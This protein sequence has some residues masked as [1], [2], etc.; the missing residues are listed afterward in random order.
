LPPNDADF[1]LLGKNE[2]TRRKARLAA[3]AILP[4]S[5][6]IIDFPKRGTHVIRV[7]N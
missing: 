4:F 3:G 5:G 1:F 6:H 2:I 7:S